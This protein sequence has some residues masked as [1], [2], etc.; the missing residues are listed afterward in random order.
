MPKL[1]PLALALLASA[2]AGQVPQIMPVPGSP[3]TAGDAANGVY[4][5]D[6][7][8]ALEKLALAQRMERLKE[9]DKSAD[10]YQEVLTQYAGRLTPSGTDA[11][12]R[13]SRYSNVQQSV[14]DKL[15]AWPADGRAVYV[16]RFG[17]AA[18]ALL[19]KAIPATGPADDAAL[20]K[21]LATYF[22]T[23][24]AKTAGL[25]LAADY[26][27]AGEFSAAAGVGRRLLNSHPDLGADRAPLLFRTALAEHLA[28]NA[29]AAAALLADLKK[30][31]P[32]AAASVGGAAKTDLADAL[33]VDLK[34][35]PPAAVAV[36]ADSWPMPFGD[37][38]RDRV[39]PDANALGLARLYGVDLKPAVPKAVP[40]NNVAELQSQRRAAADQGATTGILPAV[41]RGQLFF[42][43]NA[44]VYALDLESGL[45]LPGWSATYPDTNGA[46]AIDAWSTPPGRT[47][48]VALTP[49]SILALLGQPD[50]IA[51][52]LT[53]AS[54][55]G[56]KQLAC[57]DRATGKKRWTARLDALPVK[58]DDAGL[59]NLEMVGSPL[60]LP[61][62]GGG[63]V[64]V[65]ARGSKNGQF[66]DSY[67]VCFDLADGSFQWATYLASSAIVRNDFQPD[68][69]AISDGGSHL[70]YAGGKVFAC[71]NLGGIAGVDAYDGTIDWLSL[72]PRPEPDARRR[73]MPG[74]RRF[75]PV[76][77]AYKANPLIAE[78][79][80]LF[81]LPDDGTDALVLDAATGEEVKRID[82]AALDG[83]APFG[84]LAP[85]DR[86]EPDT[87]LGVI[88]P[89]LVLASD[90]RVY[91][92]NWPAYK[93]GADRID[94]L[95]GVNAGYFEAGDNGAHS[96]AIRGR[97][98]VTDK[99]IY[100]PTVGGLKKLTLAGARDE[101]LAGGAWAEGEGPGN[102]LVLGG[103]QSGYLIVA[104]PSRVSLYT[105]PTTIRKKLDAAVAAAPA[106]AGPRLK[107]AEVMFTSGQAAVAADKLDEARKVIGDGPKASD[108]KSR[109]R[110]F[111]DALTFAGKL[112]ARSD[113]GAEQG[114]E[115]ESLVPRLLDLAAASADS[116]REQVEWRL[117]KAA[118]LSDLGQPR[119]AAD[120]LQQVLDEAPTREVPLPSGPAASVAEAAIGRLVDRYGS[121]VIDPLN[122]RAAAALAAAMPT[123]QPTTNPTSEPSTKPAGVELMTAALLDVAAVYPYSPAAADALQAAAR[124]DETAGLRREATQVLRRLTGKPLETDR[125]ARVL[126]ALARNYL[127]EPGRH[128]VALARLAKAADLAPAAKLDQ[129]LLLPGGEKLDGDTLGTALATLRGRQSQLAEAALPDL[130]L[131]PGPLGG[132]DIM[133]DPFGTAVTVADKVATLLPP[134]AGVARNDRVVTYT[135]GPGAGL[136]AWAPGRT[137]PLFTADLPFE[138]DGIAWTDA[139]LLAWNGGAVALV[140]DAKTPGKIAWTL[141]PADLPAAADGADAGGASGKQADLGGQ[142]AALGGAENGVVDVNVQELQNLPPNVRQRV[143]QLRMQN[144]RAQRAVRANGRVVNVQVAVNGVNVGG[145]PA[146]PAAAGEVAFADV[147][148][149]SESAVVSTTDGR[150]AAVSLD[151]GKVVWQRALADRAPARLFASDVFVV[152]HFA[153]TTSARTVALDALDGRTTLARDFP[154]GTGAPTNLT[155]APDGT[156]VW[157]LPDRVSAKDLFDADPKVT[158]EQRVRGRAGIPPFQ[159]SNQPSQLVVTD[160][161][162][163]AVS[164]VMPPDGPSPTQRVLAFNLSDA[165]AVKVDAPQLNKKVDLEFN[166]NA[167]K[168]AMA[169]GLR[170]VGSRFYVVGEQSLVGYDLDRPGEFWRRFV[171]EAW[172][173]RTALAEVA[174]G[175]VV[176]IDV[177]TAGAALTPAANIADALAGR[178]HSSTVLRVQ[179]YSRERTPEGIESG[180]GR[181]WHE[182]TDPAGI[183]LDEWQA[184][185][186][187]IYYLTG[188]RKLHF[189]PGAGTGPKPGAGA[190]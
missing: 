15:A 180:N 142:I 138:P 42:Q 178:A 151:T 4:V 160:G 30:T 43:D 141:A 137:A 119:P 85:G 91:V 90:S 9:W 2:A 18:D 10:V 72:Y 109:H 6:S 26:F 87:L 54:G 140:D 122:A 143:L 187:G 17:P 172:A 65:L 75:T 171:D 111:D 134:T 177:P 29:D 57:L 84:G 47:L 5:R 19:A 3:L 164:D 69:G 7:A 89:R 68:D 8:V 174:A 44:R 190:K 149:T 97:A 123:T 83:P 82:L 36:S 185:N 125:R 24:A 58:G 170:A 156:L 167:P 34:T 28:G 31:D 56:E 148:P 152:A 48:A 118:R 32:N 115:A 70:A 105:D 116:P 131:P 92:V 183:V 33:A 120:L 158:H 135:P 128:E 153:G 95:Y 166:P 79:G 11:K 73:F 51:A 60:P 64:Y 110:L 40:A 173:G 169:V 182:L 157:L 136:S 88:G 106:D 132:G 49:D 14:Q 112:L 150:V 77:D 154:A 104:G 163:L 162:I 55:D 76:G 188:D 86:D 147:A 46:Y 103:Q 161:K 98:F 80:R 38:A 93:R 159:F 168:E 78:G 130:H 71:T 155:L 133:A 121:P 39:P 63:R 126:E 100:T 66:L 146:A 22:I 27:E 37:A 117:A 175:N 176:L 25:R 127:A 35:A 52:Q 23:P 113:K 96:G 41:D 107:Y 67:L 102:V 61:D 124:L 165:R 144:Q 181:Q 114:R 45:P 62:V 13:V 59:R 139:G 81:A 1:T 189:L 179:T 74:R 129:P 50:Q 53:G 101:D 21:L 108:G 99:T 184:V 16:A 145:A 94:F 20:H 186:G 12:N